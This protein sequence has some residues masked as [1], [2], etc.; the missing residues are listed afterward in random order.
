MNNWSVKK[1]FTVLLSAL[2]V[3]VLFNIIGMVEIAKTGYFTYLER[4]HLVGLETVNTNIEKL[5][6]SADNSDFSTIL[7]RSSSDYRQQGMTQGFQFTNQQAEACLDAVIGIEVLLF[8]I[9][10]FGEAIDI[11]HQDIEVNAQG[12]KLIQQLKNG[13]ITKEEFLS[14]VKPIQNKLEG[15]SVRFA[16]LIPEIREFMVTLIIT[17]III[18]SIALIG[19]FAY[20]LKM[21]QGN[22]THLSVDIAEVEQ[23]NNLNYVVSDLGQDDVGIVAKSFKSLLGKFAAIIKNIS[24]S[25]ATVLSESSKLKA[26]AYDS[27]ASVEQQFEMTQ[28]VSDAVSKMISAIENVGSSI[29]RVATDVTEVNSAAENGQ[30]VINETI[31]SLKNLGDEISK[32]ALVVDKL[33]TSGEQV[34]NVLEVITQIADQTNLL[35]LNAAIEAARAGE[36]G[37]GFA[38]VSDE[39]RTLANRTQE[40]TQEINTI[41]SEFKQ[42]SEAAVMAMR[43]SEEQAQETIK[44]ADGAGNSLI[45]IAGLSSKINEATSVVSDAS[46]E[47]NTALNGIQENISSLSASAEQAKTVAHKTQDAAKVLGDNVNSMNAVVSEFKV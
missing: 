45:T 8:R 2:V 21:L 11:C 15:Y 14:K 16:E 26:L 7:S 35:A 20:L 46:Q 32:A 24:S 34:S 28:Q 5:E 10:G 39:V 44:M 37:R 9:L 36:H 19:A 1:K 17:M 43:R 40:S 42:G 33:A 41:I 23:T 31:S 6:L 30:T 12:L 4:Q 29:E 27:N 47:Q 38:V 18:L 3:L 25:N 22:L 13:S